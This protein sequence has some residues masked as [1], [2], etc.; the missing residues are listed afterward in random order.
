[1]DSNW[2]IDSGA[3]NHLTR[4]LSKLSTHEQYKGHD[5]IHTTSG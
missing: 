5:Q 1:V 2:Y 3:T 4:E